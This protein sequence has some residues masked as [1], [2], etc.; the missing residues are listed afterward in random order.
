VLFVRLDYL[1]AD[2]VV[3]GVSV[4]VLLPRIVQISVEVEEVAPREV[5]LVNV[6]V[7]LLAHVDEVLP[8]HRVVEHDHAPRLLP[9][10]V[11]E[12]GGFLREVL[13]FLGL[14][15]MHQRKRLLLVV[16]HVLGCAQL[17]VLELPLADVFR[18]ESF[19]LFVLQVFQCLGVSL[20]TLVAQPVRFLERLRL[21]AL[22]LEPTAH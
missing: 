8:R 20:Q 17:V 7:H 6:S 9:A 4:V 22:V 10:L 15:R 18:F 21:V 2:V 13:N 5:D 11:G 14:L 1:L 19:F 16:D 12:V 3:L